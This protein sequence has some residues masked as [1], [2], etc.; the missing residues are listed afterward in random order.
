MSK[1]SKE[2]LCWKLSV[3]QSKPDNYLIHKV[4]IER[5]IY[6]WVFR[7]S[8][9]FS[10]LSNRKMSFKLTDVCCFSPFK[11]SFI[12][13]FMQTFYMNIPYFNFEEKYCKEMLFDA[14]KTCRRLS[15]PACRSCW[16]LPIVF[17]CFIQIIALHIVQK[18]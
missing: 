10:S 18:F 4:N 15:Y 3:L 14:N 13:M 16:C 5:F 8:V 2:V 11:N 17:P 9:R 7:K 12:L 6:M 1:Q